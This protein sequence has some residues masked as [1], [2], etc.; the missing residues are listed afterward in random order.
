MSDRSPRLPP[1][2]RATLADLPEAVAAALADPPAGRRATTEALGIAFSSL[3]WGDRPDRPLVLVH[4]VTSDAET[5]WRVGPALAASGRHVVAP[6]L[7]GHGLTHPWSGRWTFAET[8][9]EL[10]AFIRAAGLERP[11][12]EVVGHSW[13]AMVCAALPIAGIRPRVLVL[14]DPPAL[15]LSFF[16][17]YAGDPL[18]QPF[19]DLREAVRAVRPAGQD[20][21][22]GDV[23]AKAL[24]LTRFDVD[25]ARRVVLGNGDWDA[26]LGALSQQAAAGVPVRL[27]KG[28]ERTGSMVPD[29]VM[30]RLAA[31][32]GAANVFTIRDGEHSAQR[33]HPEATLVALLRALGDAPVDGRPARRRETARRSATARS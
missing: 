3:A 26:G 8:A 19:G 12:L 5:W 16:E 33:R 21:A 14:F 7:P 30:P 17:A 28:E 23:H 4:G 11:D 2:I 10:A 24:G 29:A 6:D 1:P 32:F 25:A 22:D 15:P 9:T 27:V 31:R 20:W 18:E 13:G